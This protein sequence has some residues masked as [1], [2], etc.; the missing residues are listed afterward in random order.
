MD[1]EGVEGL[2][3]AALGVGDA[4]APVLAPM[5]LPD[6]L[7]GAEECDVEEAEVMG[8]RSSNARQMPTTAPTRRRMR[9]TI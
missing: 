3:D 6:V 5:V 1:G 8:R 4:D 2:D 9:M 7:D